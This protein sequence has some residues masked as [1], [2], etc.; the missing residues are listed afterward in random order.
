[1]ATILESSVIEYFSH[2]KRTRQG[3]KKRLSNATLR[4]KAPPWGAV[5]VT[6]GL[7]VWGLGEGRRAS[8][9]TQ[10]TS[11]S[12]SDLSLIYRLNS[13][14]WCRLM[15]KTKIMFETQWLRSELWGSR[16]RS[17]APFRW[18]VNNGITALTRM[19]PRV[20]SWNKPV[21]NWVSSWSRNWDACL[22]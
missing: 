20:Q 17:H 5:E 8:R 10:N 14:V 9:L 22:K 13:G 16:R 12:R 18:S 1:M 4:N 3:S 2:L 7:K 15:V 11:Q 19:R 6:R 21:G